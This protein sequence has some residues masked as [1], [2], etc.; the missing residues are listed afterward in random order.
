M[1]R[2]VWTSIE[3]LCTLSSPVME[4]W[5]TWFSLPHL[6]KVC[7]RKFF[8]LYQPLYLSP[9]LPPS[10]SDYEKVITHCIQQGN[11]TEALK[12]LTNKAS[13]VLKLPQKEQKHHFKIFADLFYKFSPGLVKRCAGDTV[14]AW[15]KMGK[16]LEP[17]RLIPALIQ[18]N[19]PA[20]PA[21]VT[22]S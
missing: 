18:C 8:L 17:Q 6:W 11:Y 15:I 5:K 9:S 12:V 22:L 10:L 16:L 20:D 7:W 4:L 13:S 2:S 3:R 21:Q 1:C 19:Q 14:E